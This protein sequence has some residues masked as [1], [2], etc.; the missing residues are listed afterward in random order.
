[1]SKKAVIS[2]FVVCGI[3]TL[4]VVYILVGGFNADK[5]KDSKSDDKV[6]TAK[7]DERDETVKLKDGEY[8][9]SADGYA[10]PVTVKLTIK[11]G[12][13]A[14]VDVVSQNETPEFYAKAKAILP[15]IVEQNSAD[16]DVVSG[17]TITSNAIKNAVRKALI[18]AGAKDNPSAKKKV[19]STEKNNTKSNTSRM[20]TGSVNTVSASINTNTANLKDGTYRGFGTGYRGTIE[21]AVKI[22]GGRIVGID[23]L[24]HREDQPYFNMA[25][26]VITKILSGTSRVDAV[27]DATFSSNGII[28]A[29]NDALRKASVNTVSSNN[30]VIVPVAPKPPVVNEPQVPITPSDENELLKIKE[31]TKKRVDELM[32]TGKLKD[33]SYDGYGV[34][35]L[36]SGTI[37][38]TIVVSGGKVTDIKVSE[39]KPDYADDI[40]PFRGIALNGLTFFKDNDSIKNIAYM[41]LFSEYKKQITEADDMYKKAVELIG[42]KYATPIKGLNKSIGGEKKIS[43]ISDSIKQYLK[44]EHSQGKMLDSVTGATVSYGGIANSVS[45]ALKKAENDYLTGSDIN[46]LKVVA[47]GNSVDPASGKIVLKNNRKAPLDLSDLI[48]SMVKKDGQEKKVKYSEFKD[49]KLIIKDSET[50]KALV[51]GMDLS[52]YKNKGVILAEIH[53]TP[54]IRSVSLPIW[55]GNYSKN[56]IVGI[57]YS[58]DGSDWKALKNPRMD[59]IDGNNIAH[60]GQT[61]EIPK[62]WTGKIVKLRVVGKDG[63]RY[64]FNTDAKV[65]SSS[66]IKYVPKEGYDNGNISPNLFINF[67]LTGDEGEEQ[68][69]E[70]DNSKIGISGDHGVDIIER[71]GIKPISVVPYDSTVTLDKDIKNLPKGLSFD[72]KIITG[73]PEVPEAEFG[74]AFFKTYEI[75]ITGHQGKVKMIRKHKLHIFRDRD[76]DQIADVEEGDNELDSFTPHF[77]TRTLEKNKNDAPPTIEEYK[78][79]LSNFPKDDSVIIKVIN[80]PDMTKQEKQKVNLEF[81]VKGLT[82]VS[83]SVVFVNV[84]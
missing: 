7:Q 55:L 21:V 67:K 72:G 53:H 9:E 31:R 11:N 61:I 35:Y 45:N 32:I 82:K 80:E 41:V 60:D 50:G 2:V 71:V 1:M 83:K 14:A 28:N 65:G 47:P 23:I 22:S 73:I 19:G 84:K 5:T 66:T 8:T 46:E 42:K 6:V 74:S 18:K 51:N 59:N 27:S 15:K 62:G 78:A 37:K 75:V 17:A 29:V 12:K 43:I 24:S 20:F 44:N 58:I 81:T 30:N 77:A 54:S 26:G 39:K 16:V 36:S 48:I 64:D 10:G 56:Y 52:A 57:E 38:T 40:I 49:N 70:V 63:T 13:I 68:E 34:G 76:R 79:M 69:I 4:G 33:G 3:I 25:R